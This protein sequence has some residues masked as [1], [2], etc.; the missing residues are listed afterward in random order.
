SSAGLFQAPAPGTAP[1]SPSAIADRYGL[2]AAQYTAV[3]AYFLGHGVRILHEWPDRLALTVDGPAAAVN[4][5]FAT[6]VVSSSLDGR[7][8]EF[9][10]TAPSLPSPFSGEVAAISGLSGELTSFEIPLERSAT[11]SVEPSQ[12]RTTQTVNPNA[13]HNVYGLD[14]LYNYSGA[15]HYATGVGIAL[16]LWG[17]GYD[18]SDISQYF[19]QYYPSEFPAVTVRAYPVDNAPAP[20]ASA[21]DDPSNASQEL[22]LD[23]EWAGTAAPGATLDAVYAPDGPASNGYSPTDPTMEDAVNHAITQVP[24]VNV[25]SMSFGSPDGQDPSFQAA[26][27]VSFA[28]A[29]QEGITVLAASGDTGGD[30]KEGCAGGVAPQFPAS[31]PEVLAVGGTAPTLTQDP[32]GAVN[33]IES[34]PAWDLSGGGF[35]TVY[36]AQPWEEVGSAAAPMRSSGERGAP[37]VAGPAFQNIFYYDGAVA[38]GS[39]TS[40]ATPMWAGLIAEMDALRGSPLGFITPRI[41]QVG[42]LEPNGSSVDGLSDVTSGANCI[43]NAAPGWDAA[44]GW[45]SPRALSLFE[46]LAGTFVTVGLQASPSPVAP[47]G[48]LHVSVALA[49]QT[50][51]HPIPG[52]P[53]SVSIQGSYAGPCSATLSPTNVTTDASGTAN[54]SFPVPDCYFGTSVTVSASVASNGY[55][56]ENSTTISVN[57]LGLA[58]IL[59]L[60]TVF[61]YNLIAFALI[62]LAATGIGL[63]LGRRRRRTPT[64]AAAATGPNT[65]A[66]PTSAP[67]SVGPGT[68]PPSTA[69]VPAPPSPETT[70]A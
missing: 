67:S 50:S 26:L 38:Y 34:E 46:H 32:L 31:S 55:Y 62:M 18:P 70:E 27:S 9:P 23:L 59:A 52:L 39:G 12:G 51:H 35:S 3:E 45:G 10:L 54:A 7:P 42:A 44:T 53:V 63:L 11:P 60:L 68:S 28:K 41:Y 40:F 66:G 1:L 19:S 57:L 25:V 30:A 29:S 15:S 20:S 21:L 64:G 17:S 37:D 56:G 24:G 47:G 65:G 2:T 33:G 61:P 49:N 13:L 48:S 16:V 58:G 36:A 6:Q 5:A 4:A 69:P 14:Q 22:S 43:A 8:V